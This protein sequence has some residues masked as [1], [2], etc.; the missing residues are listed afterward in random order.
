VITRS[1]LRSDVGSVLRQAAD[2][3]PEQ[4]FVT[5]TET[6][7]RLTYGEFDR[8][9]NRVANA[10]SQLGVRHADFVN[11]MLPNGI[12]YLALSYA[13][14]RIG[15]IEIAVNSEFR[16]AA[17]S[18][19]LNLCPGA[20]LITAAQFVDRLAMIA[21]DVAAPR[22]VIVV[23]E[24]ERLAGLWP[25]K[26]PVIGFTDLV[27]MGG[28]HDPGVRVTD[29]DVGV[30]IFTSGTTGPSKGCLVSHRSMVRG[31]ESIRDALRLTSS[32]VFYT[33]YPLFH[34]R[35]AVLD[36]FA[37]VLVGAQAVVAPRFSASRF[38][39]HMAQFDV[40]VFSIIG[41][42]MQILWKQPASLGDRQHRVRI[43]W[44]G[45]I[46]VDPAAFEQRFGVHVLPGE[47]VYGMSETGMVSIT[48]LDP[49]TSGKVRPIYEVRIA[50]HNDDPM[51]PGETGEIL[52]RPTESGVMFSGY[53]AMAEATVA[54]WRN[55]WFH[56]GDLGRL[57]PDGR[58]IFV[59]RKKDTIRRAGHNIS[60]WEVEEVIDAHAAVLESAVIGVP[61]HLGE[62]EVKAYVVRQPGTSLTSSELLEHC[63]GKLAPF[64]VPQHVAFI[65]E[66]P[67]TQTGKPAK[68][69][70]LTLHSRDDSEPE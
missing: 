44:G 64:M 1:S 11:L 15:A 50:D 60:C 55:L 39:T 31:A 32:D 20:M 8:L 61:S 33:G 2:R 35:A 21:G 7:V 22:T 54:A 14:K 3:T 69:V 40:T 56:T 4:P 26:S 58:L 41:T 23:G 48:S 53:L 52:V 19:M 34:T 47:G 67:K 68:G 29:L 36:V 17:L 6:G 59:G 43:A 42:V 70:L 46:T 10:L 28:E 66:I 13:V 12:E 57:N 37:S 38:W 62:E 9:V 51:L 65:G 5:F 30:V 24:P 45:P 63:R 18:R 27:A 16:G 49:T 25:P